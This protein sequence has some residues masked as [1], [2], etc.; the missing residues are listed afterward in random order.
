MKTKAVI[1]RI[2]EEMAVLEID[3]EFIEIPVRLLPPG[4][5]EGDSLTLQIETDRQ[6]NLQ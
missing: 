6:K 3:S 5:K 4:V 1:D 2:E